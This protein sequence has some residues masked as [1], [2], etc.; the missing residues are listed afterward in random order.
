MEENVIALGMQKDQSFSQR[1]VDLAALAPYQDDRGGIQIDGPKVI[2]TTESGNRYE[3][4]LPN[5]LTDPKRLWTNYLACELF[6]DLPIYWYETR[7]MRINA[8]AEIVNLEC[9]N[10]FWGFLFVVGLDLPASF[11]V[12]PDLYCIPEIVA[13]SLLEPAYV[14]D[15]QAI[16]GYHLPHRRDRIL[17]HRLAE[18][19][20]ALGESAQPGSKCEVKV[21]NLFKSK[22]RFNPQIRLWGTAPRDMDL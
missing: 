2:L 20:V 6:A 17:E 1:Y 8:V 7:P 11:D 3:A 9:R 14:V 19:L 12:R 18:A 13:R 21:N 16:I 22:P 15:L 5:D 10:R 4:D